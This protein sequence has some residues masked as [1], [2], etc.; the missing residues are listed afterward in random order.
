VPLHHHDAERAKKN[1]SPR[2]LRHWKMK[3]WKRRSAV[4]RAKAQA[5]RLAAEQA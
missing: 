5:F 1:A 3:E 4:R 2:R